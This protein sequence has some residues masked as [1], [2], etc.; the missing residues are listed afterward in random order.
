MVCVRYSEYPC[1]PPPCAPYFVSAYDPVTDIIDELPN[2]GPP[3]AAGRGEGLASKGGSGGGGGS[4]SSSGRVAVAGG[5]VSW[6]YDE[7]L[8]RQLR[9]MVRILTACCVRVVSFC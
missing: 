1:T 3:G 8:E 9:D 5:V 6:G 2:V 7:Y 4:S